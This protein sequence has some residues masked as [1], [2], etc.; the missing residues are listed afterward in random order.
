MAAP[1]A[2]CARVSNDGKVTTLGPKAS[3]DDVVTTEDVKDETKL[4]RLLGKVLADVSMLRARWYPRK[5]D[6]EDVVVTA[7]LETS[8]QHNFNGRVRWWVVGWR[9]T[10][11]GSATQFENQS[12]SDANTLVLY[13]GESGIA[14]IRIEEAG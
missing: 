9:S 14:T 11:A 3:P 4:A 5:I 2:G 13:S 10:G 1:Q 12:I 7:G 6:Y 8:F